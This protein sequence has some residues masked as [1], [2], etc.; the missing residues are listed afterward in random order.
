MTNLYFRLKRGHILVFFLETLTLWYCSKVWCQGIRKVAMCLW[1]LFSKLVNQEGRHWLIFLKHLVRRWKR[2]EPIMNPCW[3]LFRL[4]CCLPGLVF[5]LFSLEYTDFPPPFLRV[6]L[7][8]WI[9]SYWCAP[10]SCP[11]GRG[12]WELLDVETPRLG[13]YVLLTSYVCFYSLVATDTRIL[14]W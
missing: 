6:F 13:I 5:S 14:Q 8:S 10:L 11:G 7:H 4:C 3:F 1:G 2:K 12:E 9:V